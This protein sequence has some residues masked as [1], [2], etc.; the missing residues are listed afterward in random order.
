MKNFSI[1]IVLI[2]LLLFSCYNRDESNSVQLGSGYFYVNS[3]NR[4]MIYKGDIEKTNTH[5]LKISGNVT[6][7]SF[8]DKF[9]TAFRHI[10]PLEFRDSS[11]NAL[12]KKQY[13]GDTLQYWIIDKA[14]DSIYGPL[15]SGKYQALSKKLN[16][17]SK[18]YLK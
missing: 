6:K 8:D 13:N 5:V 14:S 4:G 18:L 7:Y 15:D 12:F 11:T 1:L 2:S 16:L 10:T 3:S 9:I 17:R